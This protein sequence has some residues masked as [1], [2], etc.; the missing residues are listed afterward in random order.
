MDM[1]R[2]LKVLKVR[3]LKTFLRTISVD[4]GR[5]AGDVGVGDNPMVA[6]L[7]LCYWL[8]TKYISV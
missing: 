1:G 5:E 2:F 3:I 7:L 4:T 6:I 8:H